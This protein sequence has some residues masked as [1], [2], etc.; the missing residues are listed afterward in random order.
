MHNFESSVARS[1]EMVTFVSFP[2]AYGDDAYKNNGPK[3]P[4]YTDDD[5]EMAFDFEDDDFLLTVKGAPDVLYQRC[6]S[7]VDPAGGPPIILD[8]A[9]MT[10]ILKVQE[11]WAA[12]GRRV[13]LLARRT[14]SRDQ[15]SKDILPQSQEFADMINELNRDLTIVGL[16]GLIDPLKEDIVHT[17][18]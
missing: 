8:E 12:Q 5:D 6:S 18:R 7:V 14:I 10:S 15:L 4:E 16:V 9:A 1:L 2:A 3:H 13:L 11:K 17:V